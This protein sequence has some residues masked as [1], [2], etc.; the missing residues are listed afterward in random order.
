[1]IVEGDTVPDAFVPSG[2]YT[3]EPAKLVMTSRN[4]MQY[5]AGSSSQLDGKVTYSNEPNSPIKLHVGTTTSYQV[6]R[7]NLAN[8]TIPAGT[9]TLSYSNSLIRGLQFSVDLKN[10]KNIR[11]GEY[12][13]VYKKQF[14]LDEPVTLS[15]MTVSASPLMQTGD[16]TIYPMIEPGSTLSDWVSGESVETNLPSNVNLANGDTLT[17]DR[18]GITTASY[19]LTRYDAD[20]V[21]YDSNGWKGPTKLNNSMSYVVLDA[22]MPPGGSWSEDVLS[23][24]RV[25]TQN[26]SSDTG[27]FPSVAFNGT[28]IHFRF[29]PSKASSLEEVK[30]YM[31]EIGFYVKVDVGVPEVE[32]LDNVSLPELPAPT[33]NV[34]TTGGYVPP[35]V[36][37][38]YEQDVSLVIA[39][40]EAKLEAKIASLEV[41]QAIMQG[42]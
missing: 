11:I 38:D 6:F 36:D 34:Y 18:D 1:M 22:K 21:G 32:T 7:L 39:N 16:Y 24:V 26:D 19:R 29:D 3:V 9:Y 23:N 40:L 33:F 4:F 37:V 41:N 17:I 20:S 35:T 28:G 25:S 5:D 2:V 14:V 15:R 31:R 10:G 13:N 27:P 30:S 8:I 42:A 12:D